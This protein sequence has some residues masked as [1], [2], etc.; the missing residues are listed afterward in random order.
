MVSKVGFE[1]TAP[2]GADLQ[3]A[4]IHRLPQLT[5]NLVLDEGIDPS[6]PGPQPSVLPLSLIQHN[7]WWVQSVTIRLLYVFSVA[8]LPS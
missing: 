2:E 1:P 5:H 4:G 6:L 8:L 7:I 3:S